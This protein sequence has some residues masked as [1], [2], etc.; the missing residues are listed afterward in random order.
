MRGLTLRRCSSI[1]EVPTSTIALQDSRFR[2]LFVRLCTTDRIV[3]RKSS[4]NT[5]LIGLLSYTGR[6]FIQRPIER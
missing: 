1:A 4:C 2:A 5:P 6:H 3:N